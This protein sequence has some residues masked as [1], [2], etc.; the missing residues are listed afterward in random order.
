[1]GTDVTIDGATPS[2][3]VVTAIG[4]LD[5]KTYESRR[6]PL[7]SGAHALHGDKPYG[8]VAYGYATAGSYAF[9]GGADVARI[10]EPPPLK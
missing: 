4:D 8:A 3:C 10:Y 7:D 6:C 1:M 2:N 9:A 5:S